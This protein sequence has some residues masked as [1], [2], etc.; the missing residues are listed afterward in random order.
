[1]PELP[2][3]ETVRRGIE[4]FIQG[5]KIRK[6]IIRNKNLRWPVPASIRLKTKN[7]LIKLVDRRAKYIL[8]K[9]ENGTIIIHLGM[10]GVLKIVDARTPLLKHDHLDIV[11]N[12]DIRLRYNDPRRFGSVLWT[13]K[14][15]LKHKLLKD[16]APE[17]LSPGFNSNYLSK[18]LKTRKAPI[19][20]VL[21]DSKTVVG[22]GNI[23]ASESLFLSKINPVLPANKLSQEQTKLLV[24]NIKKV[25]RA[26]IKAGG[27]TLKD[28]AQADG[29]PGYFAQKLLVYGKQ[30]EPCPA[31]KTPIKQIVLG[32]RATYYCAK[33]QK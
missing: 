13:A 8:L 7:R 27:T 9:L 20:N 10:S 11:L 24:K 3:V 14:D 22:V 33:C 31:C 23:Y 25:L 16:L 15:P 18:K 26:S 17:P 32:Q 2:E 30:A 19:K 12:D 1:M 28:F 6:I 21:M 5:R 29:R 4:P